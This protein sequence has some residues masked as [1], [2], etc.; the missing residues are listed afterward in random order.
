V[1]VVL[2]SFVNTWHKISYRRYDKLSIINYIIVVYK[3]CWSSPAQSFSGQSP[4]TVSDGRA[5]AQAVSRRLPIAA[6]KVRVPI[7]SCGIYGEQSGIG[8][9][10]LRGLR[11]PLLILIPPTAPDSSSSVIQ[12]WYSRSNSDR[13]TKWTQSHATPRNLNLNLLALI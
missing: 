11:F 7:R 5:I 4:V 8:A 10:F 1:Y 6:A 12:G 3:C 13:R 9:V 2:K